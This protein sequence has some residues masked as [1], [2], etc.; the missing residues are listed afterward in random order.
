ML[1]I[2]L[3]CCLDVKSYVAFPSLKKTQLIV[4]SISAEVIFFVRGRSVMANVCCVDSIL[5]Y[6][7]ILIDAVASALFLPSGD[8]S[9]S[10]NVQSLSS[11]SW[12]LG[13]LKR[14][15]VIEWLSGTG[16]LRFAAS[17]STMSGCHEREVETTLRDRRV[18]TTQRFVGRLR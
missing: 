13:S 12:V 11:N 8:M 1:F 18:H 6:F 15:T 10:T 2:E 17:G 14:V 7:L 16:Q 3:V 4:S 5:A 9:S